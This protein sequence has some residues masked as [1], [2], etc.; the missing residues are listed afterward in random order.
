MTAPSPTGMR[1]L[2]LLRLVTDN[3][4]IKI[5]LLILVPLI[6]SSSCL[7]LLEGYER[8]Q[9]SQAQIEQQ[10]ELLLES[11]QK[12][13]RGHVEMAK[14]MVERIAATVPDTEEAQRRA[15]ERLESLRF[16]GN[17]YIFVY[18]S[19]GLMLVQPAL[20]DR[21]GTSMLDATDASGQHM[22]RDMAEIAE[23]GG[24][25]YQYEWPHPETGEPET[26]YSY[27][28]GVDGWDWV[29]GAGVYITDVE[30][31]ISDIEAAAWDSLIASFVRLFFIASIINLAIT[32]LAIWFARR[33]VKQIQT[34]AEGI[35]EVASEVAAGK[36][37]LTRRLTVHSHDEIGRLGEQFNAF[38]SRMQLMLRDVQ[39]SAMEVHVAANDIAQG[40]EELATRTDQAAASLQQTSSAMEEITSTV[41]S[42]SAQAQQA[43]QLVKS[44]AEVAQQGQLAM[45]EVEKNMDDISH[46]SARIGDIV[47]MIDSIAFQTNIL[48]LNASVEAA[49]A[50]EHGRGFAVVAQEVRKLAQRSADSAR[51]IKTL[52]ESSARLSQ[53]GTQVVQRTGEIMR[54]I[55]DGVNQV[56]TVISEISAGSQEQSI[57][58][59]EVNTAVSQLDTMTQ[60]NAAMVEQS[61]GTAIQMRGQAERLSQLIDSF[62]LGVDRSEV[63]SVAS[64]WKA[65]DQEEDPEPSTS[66][67]REC[68]REPVGYEP[69]WETF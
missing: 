69:E 39:R 33:T 23:Q 60:Q 37:D 19:D 22:I 43:D 16:E 51:D 25:F 5:L 61:S 8:F 18:Q 45:Q 67:T 47:S 34:T 62:E 64:E 63:A 66:R 2:G 59:A 28:D 57:G 32:A 48:A 26:K 46:S 50:G 12:G 53:G 30:N 58:I 14:S 10:R 68:R 4:Q 65:F 40:S 6:I 42:T 7:L 44:T 9:S 52:V 13:V 24:G 56:T 17:N 35:R 20:P 29:L 3:L 31:A 1:R 38:M 21:V 36:G 49:R 41:D 15:I 11:R 55:F 54:E 27:A